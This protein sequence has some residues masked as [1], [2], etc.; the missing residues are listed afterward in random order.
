MKT[1][2]AL[3]SLVLWC[4]PLYA[5]NLDVIKQIESGG[6]NH[7]ESRAGAIGAYQIRGCV[8]KEYNRFTRSNLK[9]SSLRNEQKA[10]TVADWYLHRRIPYLLKKRRLPIT[11]R[12][13]LI[14]YNAGHT[15]VGKK[16]PKET[17]EY[18]RRYYEVLRKG[19][20]Q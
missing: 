5:V 15:R 1:L 9:I 17:Q 14:S 12:N 20:L 8:L 6:R 10:R 16:L 4:I 7:A 18:I 19:K 11:L 3:L 13:Q 2:S